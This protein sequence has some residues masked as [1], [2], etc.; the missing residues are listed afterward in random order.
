[1]L[2]KEHFCVDHFGVDEEWQGK[3]IGGRLLGKACE[4][5]DEEGLDMFVEANANAES[6][7]QKFGF[8]TEGK[9]EM[10]GGQ[11]ECFLV[12]RFGA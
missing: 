11:T 9:E 5:A 1:M 12:K 3:G 6:F 10:P 8:K 2:G 7:Y 4:V